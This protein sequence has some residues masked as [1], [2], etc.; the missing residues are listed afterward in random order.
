MNSQQFL[1]RFCHFYY[2]VHLI[3]A[4]EKIISL[5]VAEKKRRSAPGAGVW[6]C[7]DLGGRNVVINLV[8]L[9][10]VTTINI[11]PGGTST[12]TGPVIGLWWILIRAC[13]LATLSCRVINA[14]L[15]LGVDA[16]AASRAEINV[17]M[18]CGHDSVRGRAPIL[19]ILSFGKFLWLYI[20]VQYKE[21]A[22]TGKAV[23]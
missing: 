9:H 5:G 1:Y 14:A 17:R 22:T 18:F 19:Y 20:R 8:Y 10:S 16:A 4:M 7:W 11:R 21:E 15:L 23:K 12:G 3:Y 2:F 13:H 6:A